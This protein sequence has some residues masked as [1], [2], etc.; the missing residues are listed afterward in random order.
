MAD[1]TLTQVDADLAR[2]NQYQ[3]ALEGFRRVMEGREVVTG[4]TAI[5]MRIALEDANVDQDEDKGVTGKDIATGFKKVAVTVRN[6]VQWLLRTI[7]KLVEKLGLG[8]QK[9]G[10]R[11]RK[12]KEALAA[13]PEVERSALGSGESTTLSPEVLQPEMLAIE[14]KFVGNDAESLN[15]VIKIGAWI[16]KDFP[17]MFDKVMGETEQLARKH[18]K[19]DTS[20]AFFKALSGIIK[21]GISKPP[22]PFSSD[23]LA[24]SVMVEGESTNT[25]P[26]MGD[27]G[28]VLLNPNGGGVLNDNNPIEMLRGWFTITKLSN[29][30]N[31][32]IEAN[33]DGAN[34]VRSLMDKRIDTVNSLLDEMAKGGGPGAHGEIA[35]CIGVMLQRL[36]ECLT[37][38]HGWYGRTLGQELGY[39]TQCLEQGK[40]AA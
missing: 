38:T 31:S 37:A 7:G 25:V 24:P 18:M 5:A 35:M 34:E 2:L 10:A 17:K 23:N 33:T 19:D 3:L 6:I 1:I 36:T 8:M 32:S 13:M 9:L 12:V 40:Q 29:M 15:N 28:L 4:P 14:G 21:S 22:V 11:S 26:F 27:H 20:E 16:N 30:I 39:L